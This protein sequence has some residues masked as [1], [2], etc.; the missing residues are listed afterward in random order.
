M[1]FVRPEPHV[2]PRV[3]A[4]D[5]VR[6]RAKRRKRVDNVITA[7]LVV[8]ILVGMLLVSPWLLMLLFGA[9]HHSVATVVPAYGYGASMIIILAVAVIK[10][11][12]EVFRG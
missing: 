11:L 8:I 7:I 10:G 6:K 3:R 9:V 12:V 1:S 2:S 4:L 5:A